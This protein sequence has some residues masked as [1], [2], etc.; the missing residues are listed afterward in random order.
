VPPAQNS[1]QIFATG[2]VLC[3]PL[4]VWGGKLYRRFQP[5]KRRPIRNQCSEAARSSKV[6]APKAPSWGRCGGVSGTVLPLA[7]L[8]QTIADSNVVSFLEANESQLNGPT[9]LTSDPLTRFLQG[10]SKELFFQNLLWIFLHDS[11]VEPQQSG[12]RTT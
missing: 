2:K 4:G 5:V 7:H 11:I 8:Q 9:R 10:R 6:K 3:T 12:V 1:R